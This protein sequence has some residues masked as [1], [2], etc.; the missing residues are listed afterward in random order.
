MQSAKVIALEWNTT[1]LIDILVELSARY[2]WQPIYCVSTGTQD[3]LKER[4]PF[5]IYHDTYDARYDRPPPEL[6]DMLRATIDQPTAE[7]LCFAEVMAL[8][9]MDRMEMMGGFATHDRFIHFH[10]LAGYWSALL[11]R[12]RPDVLLMPTSPHV[13]YDYLAYVLARRRGIPTIMF[14]YVGSDG[15][16]MAINGFED[17][18][19]PL[20]AAYRRLR[21]NPP[22]APIVLS[23]RM[24]AYWRSLHGTYEQ[25][26]PY[27]LRHNWDYQRAYEKAEAEAT[28]AA[29]EAAERAK[30]AAEEAAERAKKAAEEAAERA[31]K[32][33]EEAAERAKK[34]A[35][36]AAEKAKKAGE[37]ETRLAEARKLAEAEAYR[38]HNRLKFCLRVMLR[39][40]PASQLLRP[41]AIACAVNEDT[42]SV[43][44][45]ITSASVGNPGQLLSPPPIAFAVPEATTSVELPMH[46]ASVA[47]PGQLLS[48]PPIALAVPE[49]TTSVELPVPPAPVGAPPPQTHG[50]YKGRFYRLQETPESYAREEAVFRRH[51]VGTLRQRYDEL[52][53][54]PDLEQPYV[55][56]ALHLQPERATNP[57]GGVFDDQHIM[58]EMI[59][60]VL[61]A[62]WRIYVKEHPVQF[63]PYYASERGRWL[64]FYDA[65]LSHP[66][67][68]LVSTST[69]SFEL[70]DGARAVAS[71]TGT[72]CWEAI[73]RGVPAL[74]FGEAWYKGCDGAH[75]VRTIG[76]CRRAL[77]KIAAGERPNAD[78]VRLFLSAAEETAVR[79]YL[80]ADDEGIAGIDWATNVSS[81][82]DAIAGCYRASVGDHHHRVRY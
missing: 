4:F 45:P 13:T 11:D 21:A 78:A 7:A 61:P 68:S 52:A 76:D 70:I 20:Q 33:A 37:Q 49:P 63:M 65:V 1:M 46:S 67:V 42:T 74:V 62:E 22:P 28:K 50:H 26:M 60:S 9:Q 56:V 72:S 29:D 80:T 14:E 51:H 6:A 35:E 41:P 34:A 48:P 57:N 75:T 71:I 79:G 31:K 47:A 16:L 8:K 27:W 10:R 44:V 73:A 30:K 55:Y 25:A 59:A 39:R 19:P 53:I 17:G 66:T 18:L 77:A 64:T 2:D 54:G 43:E 81:L 15:L 38:W 5:A 82:A 23:E 40:V 3:Y 69:S 58:V 24:E 32:A 36:E 12:L